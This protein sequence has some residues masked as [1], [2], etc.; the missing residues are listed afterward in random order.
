MQTSSDLEPSHPQSATETGGAASKVAAAAVQP[1]VADEQAVRRQLLARMERLKPWRQNIGITEDISTGSV[2]TLNAAQ[3]SQCVQSR[4]RDRDKFLCLVDNLYPAGLHKKRFLDCGC[5][6]GGYCFWARERDAELAFGFDAREHWI[7]QARMIKNHRTVG[8]TDF[9]RLEVMNLY[10]L[11]AQDLDPFDLVQFKG[12]FYHLADPIGGLKIAADHC[13]DV[14]LFSTAVIWGQADGSL[15][16]ELQEDDKL[17]GSTHRL[18]WF[19]TGPKIC[20][21]MIRH[22]GFESIKLTRYNQVK[23]RPTRGRLEIVAARDKGRLD[24]IDGEV[25]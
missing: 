3:D 25:I 11:P 14:L 4:S 6:A 8:P 19:P 22:L 1:V 23:R 17:H 16:S 7:K 24:E 18:S 13:R 5:N 12:M 10:D 20:V 21:E 15:Q 2:L 9:V